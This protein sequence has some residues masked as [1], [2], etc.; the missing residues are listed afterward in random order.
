MKILRNINDLKK[1]VNKIDNL[2]FVPTMGG[3]HEGHISIINQSKKKSNKTLVSIYVNPKQFNNSTDYNSYPKNT[4]NDLIKLKK[5]GVDFVF[6]PKSKD[7]YRKKR[8]K[9]ITIS[10]KY[11]VLCGKFRKGHFEGVLDVVDRLLRLV[12]PKF[13]FL[14]E[15]D[16]QQYFLIK[17][18]LKK[19]HSI[20]IELCKTVRDKNFVP[21]STRNKLL[22]KKEYNI[23]VFITNELFLLKKNKPTKYKINYLKKKIKLNFKIKVDYL[24]FRNSKNLMTN[25][26]INIKK[27]FIAYNLGNVRLID[28][29]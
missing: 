7:V 1:A 5:I 29:I 24:E 12:K 20:K 9:K 3:L 11:K 2:G 26:N 21:L 18:Y 16:F 14:G 27:L 19:K 28:N 10:S 15:K 6:L 4:N 25:G 17:K 8:V 22:S 13:L 23:A